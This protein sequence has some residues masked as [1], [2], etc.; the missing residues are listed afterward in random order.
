MRRLDGLTNLEPKE[1]VVRPGASPPSHE[2]RR[3]ESTAS[4]RRTPREIA[5]KL[6]EG[7]PIGCFPNLYKALAG[8]KIDQVITL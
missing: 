8:A 1:R 3:R 5:D 7:I 4:W 6:I 2:M